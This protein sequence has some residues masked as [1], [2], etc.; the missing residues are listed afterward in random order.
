METPGMA[1][2]L[3]IP[4]VLLGALASLGASYR[5]PNFIIDAPTEQ[6]AREVGQ[7][8]EVYRKEKAIQWLGRE[9]PQWPAPCPV[10]VTIQADGAG[11]ATTFS[12]G[13]EGVE[14]QDMHVEGRYDRILNS[15]LP[16][17]ITHTVFAYYFRCPVPRWADEG[18][19]VL[20]EDQ[21]ERNRHDQLAKGILNGGRLVPLRRLFVVKEYR[22][23]DVMSLYAEGYSVS[24]FLVSQGGEK[25]RQ[26]FLNFVAAGMRNNDWSGAAR[27]Y[28]GYRDVNDLEAAWVDSLRRPRTAPVQLATNNPATDTESTRRVV[29]RQTAPPMQVTLESPRPAVRGQIPPED[30][31]RYAPRSPAPSASRPG[32]PQGYPT[33]S[34]VPAAMAPRPDVP[35]PVML[36]PPQ[37]VPP[38]PPVVL[39][40][41]VPAGASPVGYPH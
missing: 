31:D 28:Y 17:E 5:T 8:A 2:R 4:L 40:S 18:G 14:S 41:P 15:V 1:R 26:K 38:P 20:S 33:G 6:V 27:S 25:G 22:E 7:Y 3:L 36:G 32:V 19:S 24:N 13:P 23:C 37:V 39:G 29:S 34:G 16:H 21:P 9:M 11:G 10:K 30:G 12:Y 35:G